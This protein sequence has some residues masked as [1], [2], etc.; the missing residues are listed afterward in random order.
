MR[1]VQ[2]AKCLGG[3]E[4][5]I[6]DYPNDLMERAK[7]NLLSHIGHREEHLSIYMQ[8]RI[9]PKCQSLPTFGKWQLMSGGAPTRISKH[10]KICS[11]R[12]S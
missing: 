4:V 6:L 10:P 8:S 5:R 7:E 1:K 2:K 9:Y 12:A 3:L 11:K